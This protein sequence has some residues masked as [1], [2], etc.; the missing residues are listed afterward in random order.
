MLDDKSAGAA[1]QAPSPK[2]KL[3][4]QIGDEN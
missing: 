4:I 3:E 2:G 1:T